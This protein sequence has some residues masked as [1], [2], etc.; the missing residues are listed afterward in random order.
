MIIHSSFMM[1]DFA[2][3]HMTKYGWTAGKGLGAREDG[4]S[5][6]IKVKI[7]ADLNGVG[8]N[9]SKQ[10]TN[11]W[12]EDAF[13]SASANIKIEKADDGIKIVSKEN[14]KRR[15]TKKKDK[16]PLHIIYKNF[17]QSGVLADGKVCGEEELSSSDD[18]RILTDDDLFRACGGR[19]AHKGARHGCKQ[20]AKLAR[21]ADHEKSFLNY[22]QPKKM[23]GNQK[24]KRE[25]KRKTKLETDN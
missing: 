11:F 16:K 15:V 1:S 8:Y 7:K 13:R 25:T 17:V 10:F 9:A 5:E 4:R 23:L 21:L 20:S 22:Y 14:R 18:D 3:S 12:W 6:P 19:T 2:K 24:L